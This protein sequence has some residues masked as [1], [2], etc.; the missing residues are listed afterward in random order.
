MR[1]PSVISDG[2]I[3]AQNC[4]IWGNSDKETSVKINFIGKD[5]TC[6][7]SNSGYW[8]MEF[9]ELP[10]GGPYEMRVND[11]T[12]KDILVGMVWLCA[13]QSNMELPIDRVR[14]KYE[15]ELLE[16]DYIRAFT[17]RKAYDFV[18]P[19]EELYE[20]FWAKASNKELGAF[21]AAGY[22]FAKK[23][24][25]ELGIPVGLICCAAGGSSIESWI[26]PDILA[27]YPYTADEIKKLQ[28]P[29]YVEAVEEEDNKRVAKWHEKLDEKDMGL[30]NNFINIRDCDWSVRPL[31]QTWDN[32]LADLSGSVWFRREI[33]FDCQPLNCRLFLGRITDSDQVYV[34]GEY[35]G[36]TEYQY[37]PRIYRIPDGLFRAGKNNITVRVVSERGEGGFCRGKDY[38]IEYSQE[39]VNGVKD[40]NIEE[41]WQYKIGH[42][43]P[44]LTPP[45]FFYEKPTGLYNAMFK[46]I[47]K[48]GTNG[49]LWYQGETNGSRPENYSQLFELLTENWRSLLG[50]ETP[51]IYVQLPGYENDDDWAVLRQQQLSCLRVENTAM[52]VAIDI[53]EYND[54]H[55][56]NKKDVGQR[57][58]LAALK[59]MFGH[60]NGGMSPIIESACYSDG[61]IILTFK[62]TE[63][64]LTARAELIFEISYDGVL[65]EVIEGYI[66]GN[67]VIIDCK[68]RKGVA[69]RYAWANN[70]TVSLY[71]GIGLPASPFMVLLD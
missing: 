8:E 45:V 1:L 23:M 55:P 22:F 44:N 60:E 11:K 17:V 67:R 26:S 66:K 56:L 27:D 51:F 71:N 64:G 63:K 59:M 50:K 61:E 69:V 12:I 20:G 28:T 41:E 31:T 70:P 29:G 3:L 14:I 52:V 25:Q 46:P 33:I 48:Y 43:M 54:L 9:K 38:K 49:V 24:Y 68:G 62:N 15:D 65:F 40:L 6:S 34:N 58:A 16:S 4:R 47:S 13:G 53:G 7:C 5:Y 18:N 35:V 10:I 2:M 19:W 42:K 36:G 37:P 30:K 21:S 32:E 39:G 57:L